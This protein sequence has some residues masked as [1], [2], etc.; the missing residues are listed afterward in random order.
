MAKIENRIISGRTE[1]R[2]EGESEKI[3]GYGSVFYDPENP[4]TEFELWSL[5]TERWQPAAF[6]RSIKE[7][8]IR[9]LF[10]HDPSMVLGRLVAGT[11]RLAV[12]EK[13]LRYEIDPPATTL[14]RDLLESLRRGDITGSSISFEV[15]EEEWRTEDERNIREIREVKL[16]DV[17]PVTFPAF[18]ATSA[19]IAKRS[20]ADWQAGQS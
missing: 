18:A 8:D 9:A 5:V 14:G 19:E 20:L 11:L 4:G 15:I 2:V 12:D 3:A 10:N 17:G 13:G 7:D 1:I 6:N 16:W